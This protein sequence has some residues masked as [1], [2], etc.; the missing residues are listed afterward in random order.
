MAVSVLQGHGFRGRLTNVRRKGKSKHREKPG[1]GIMPLFHL[2][3]STQDP[4]I[5][6][7]STV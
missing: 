4:A 2:A 5:A 6:S 7:I 1:G 3:K